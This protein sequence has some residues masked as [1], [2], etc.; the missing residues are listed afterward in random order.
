L[1]R[2][3]FCNFW[4]SAPASAPLVF[5]IASA[6]RNPRSHALRARRCGRP[7][8]LAALA[9]PFGW[10]KP[11]RS[12]APLAALYRSHSDRKGDR[13][14]AGA[15]RA[16]TGTAPRTTARRRGRNT[17]VGSQDKLGETAKTCYILPAD[18]EIC[19]GLRNLRSA[20]CHGI[21]PTGPGVNQTTTS[22]HRT[23]TH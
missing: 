22:F 4:V 7:V 17:K 11:R 19:D 21:R 8:G 1:T 12:L 23:I 9:G 2:C 16:A 15:R 13:P 6:M 5:R 3:N 18:V 20:A 14:P 10:R